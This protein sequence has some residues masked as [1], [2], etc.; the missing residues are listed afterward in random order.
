MAQ[1]VVIKT[2]KNAAKI[3]VDGNEISDVI[4][5]VLSEDPNGARLTI[6]ISITGE[7]EVRL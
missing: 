7:I 3:V 1:T 6:E 4:S 2:E 5:Y